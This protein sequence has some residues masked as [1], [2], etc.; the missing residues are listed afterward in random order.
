MVRSV[1]VV[2]VVVVVVVVIVGAL[3]L[4]KIDWYR[5]V[6]LVTTSAADVSSHLDLGQDVRDAR[7][8]ALDLD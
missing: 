2:M 7:D 1:V 3:Y 4:S 8:D 5:L 6:A